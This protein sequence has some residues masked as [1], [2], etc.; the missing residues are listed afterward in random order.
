MGAQLFFG[1][2]L[3]GQ[4]PLGDAQ[5]IEYVPIRDIGVHTLD[6]RGDEFHGFTNVFLG[7]YHRIDILDIHHDIDH[8]LF[9]RI[10]AMATLHTLHQVPAVLTRPR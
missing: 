4:L 9:I 5:C 8:I 3:F 7:R 10:D 6:V 2:L 1:E